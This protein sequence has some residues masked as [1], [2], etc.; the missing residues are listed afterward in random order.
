M[1]AIVENSSNSLDPNRSGG[2]AGDIPND[3][4]GE[5]A[6]VTCDDLIVKNATLML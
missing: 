4:T 1:A 6:A 5:F 2:A 3:G